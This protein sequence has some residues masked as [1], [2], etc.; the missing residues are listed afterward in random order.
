MRPVYMRLTVHHSKKNNLELKQAWPP[1][2]L[3]QAAVSMLHP[4]MLRQAPQVPAAD[5]LQRQKVTY[6]ENTP[7]VLLVLTCC[8]FARLPSDRIH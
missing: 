1:L 8:G 6:P 4:D 2:L 5:V 7:S 3:T